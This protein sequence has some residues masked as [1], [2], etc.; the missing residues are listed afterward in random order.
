[1]N[2]PLHPSDTESYNPGYGN[3]SLQAATTV[4]HSWHTYCA[5]GLVERNTNSAPSI[6]TDW[7]GLRF[8]VVVF[9]CI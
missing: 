6:P 5:I 7:K 2:S 8:A 9:H 4:K 1:M 3:S